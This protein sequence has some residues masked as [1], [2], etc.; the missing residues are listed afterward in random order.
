MN[1][2]IRHAVALHCIEWH[3]M[4]LDGVVWHGGHDVAWYGTRLHC[5]GCMALHCISWCDIAWHD[6]AVLIIHT[7]A[8][9]RGKN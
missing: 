7:T 8:V 1:G 3:A 4:L 9:M 5:T 2:V 6:L